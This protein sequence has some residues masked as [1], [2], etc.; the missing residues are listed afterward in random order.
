VHIIH[1]H[2]IKGQCGLLWFTV[3]KYNLLTR[4][5]TVTHGLVLRGLYTMLSSDI[6]VRQQCIVGNSCTHHGSTGLCPIGK[7][8][9]VRLPTRFDPW[10]QVSHGGY[11]A[12]AIKIGQITTSLLYWSLLYW[13][14]VSRVDFY[15]N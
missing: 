8:C 3:H 11:P 10:D 14:Q 2:K 13:Y 5:E 1:S 7:T 6:I 4:F 15:L 9:H 12:S